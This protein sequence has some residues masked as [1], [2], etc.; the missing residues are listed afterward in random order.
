MKKLDGAEQAQQLCYPSLNCKHLRAGLKGGI[1]VLGGCTMHFVFVCAALVELM[2]L[3]G[4][5]VPVVF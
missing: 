4:H 1:S 2:N 5:C 3:R